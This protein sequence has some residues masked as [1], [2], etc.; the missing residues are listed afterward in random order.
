MIFYSTLK[1][2]ISF[3]LRRTIYLQPWQLNISIHTDRD[4]LVAHVYS[5]LLSR[6]TI[7]LKKIDYYLHEYTLNNLIYYNLT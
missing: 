7:L 2:T 6:L 3:N 4:P 5:N 1:F